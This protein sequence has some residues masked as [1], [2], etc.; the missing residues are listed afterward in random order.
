MTE[1]ETITPAMPTSEERAMAALA[2]GSVVLSFLGALVPALIWVT[3]RR[4]SPFVAFHALQAAGYQMLTFWLGLAAYLGFILLIFILLIPFSDVILEQSGENPAGTAMQIQWIV[5]LVFYG[6]ILLY[7]LLGI[8]GAIFCLTGRDF[9]YPFLGKRLETYLG[10]GTDPNSPLDETKEDQWMS[11]IGHASAILLLWGLFL[12]LAMYLIQKD[13]S[14]RLRFQSAQAAVYQTIATAAYFGFGVCYLASFFAI[15]A[16]V[17]TIPVMSSSESMSPQLTIAL[18]VFLLV[19]LVLGIF[20][21]LGLPTYH[22]FAMIA[23]IQTLKGKDYRY[24][25]LGNFIARRMK[26][27]GPKG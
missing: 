21:M 11:A 26:M 3:H 5:S 20:V 15:L 27:D 1:S 23:G 2:H 7:S 12:P 10:R 8:A 6:F 18:L 4:K 22:L 24:P 9:K 25:L 14:P 17:V 16:S 13:S 19:F